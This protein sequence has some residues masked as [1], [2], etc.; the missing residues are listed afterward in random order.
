MLTVQVKSKSVSSEAQSISAI[1]SAIREYF[2][3]G[4]EV[5]NERR[6][7]LNRIIEESGL[8][9]YLIDNIVT[10]EGELIQCSLQLPT[11]EELRSAFLYNSRHLIDVERAM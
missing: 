2:F 4:R 7:I 9:N 8:H 3:Y 6:E 1:H 11:W 5:L 10:E